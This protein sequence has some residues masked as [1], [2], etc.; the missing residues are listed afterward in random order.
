MKLALAALAGEGDATPGD[1]V[2]AAFVA[3]LTG[4]I[5]IGIEYPIYVMIRAGR[6]FGW[7]GIS[8]F[9]PSLMILALFTAWPLGIASGLLIGG[10]AGCGNRQA[11]LSGF[12]TALILAWP[13]GLYQAEPWIFVGL[14]ASGIG[15]GLFGWRAVIG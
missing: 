9:L 14:L 6:M 2:M 7:E 10:I 1:I 8:F 3:A 12:L 11:A 13:L 4:G 5:L 15:A